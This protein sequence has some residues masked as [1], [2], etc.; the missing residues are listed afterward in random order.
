MHDWQLGLKDPYS[1]LLTSDFR[2][3]GIHEKY[4]NTWELQL[5]GSDRGGICLYSTLSLR[6][7]STRIFPIFHNGSHTA[8]RSSEFIHPPIIKKFLSNYVLIHYT[9]FEG[10]DIHTHI[11]LP[12]N[13]TVLSKTIL[14]NNA[15]LPFEGAINWV[16]TLTPLQ[17]GSA[18][19]LEE[20]DRDFYLT[21]QAQDAYAAF[22]LGNG[23]KAGATSYPSLF[24]PLQIAPGGQFAHQW[25]F[26]CNEDIDTL[27]A[28]SKPLLQADFEPLAARMDVLQ[29]RDEIDI[30]TTSS[31]W[32]AAFAFSQKNALQLILPDVEQDQPAT[33]LKSRN[34]EQQN[35][36]YLHDLPPIE[37]L[38]LL[39]IWYLSGVIPGAIST[40]MVLLD[41]Y[42]RHL[43]S[44]EEGLSFQPYPILAEMIWKI[45]E[46]TDNLTW[47]KL[48]YP[49]LIE[50]LKFWFTESQD[51]DQD[52][53][54]EWQ[55]ALQSQF[56][57]L[58]VHNYWHP[59]GA[60]T[61]TSWIESPFL[62]GLLY[63]ELNR[64][65][66]IAA[67]LEIT[68]EK[69]WLESK[70]KSLT[71]YINDSFHNR[72][73]IFKYR[74]SI[75]HASPNGYKIFETDQAG[76]YKINKNLR[77]LQRLNIKII[78]EKENTRKTRIFIKGK[79]NEGNTVEEISTR[80]FMGSDHLRAATSNQVY[81]KIISIEVENLT[82]GD[83]VIVSTAD[84]AVEDI[85]S[86]FPLWSNDILPQRVKHIKERWLIPEL[87]QPFGLPLVPV[88]KQPKKSD[89]FN[90][91]DLYLNRFILE[92]LIN[93]N[94]IKLASELYTNL[95]NAVIKNLKLFKR[96]YKT[97]DASDGY[98]SGDYNIVNGLLPVETFLKLIGI[99]FWS[100]SKIEFTHYN[101]FDEPIQVQNRA[102]TVVCGRDHFEIIFPGGDRFQIKGIL[103]QRFFLTIPTTNK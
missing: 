50:S 47:L 9:P 28:K 101:P 79:T 65:V 19:K 54:P 74:D 34:P 58:P 86:I 38:S 46:K 61:N 14:K 82:Q 3:R 25:V 77:G 44:S 35:M 5:E 18:A 69:A 27:Y 16:M 62:A 78:N 88:S 71:A 91:V 20:K 23:A 2:V 93:H 100:E 1:L 36:V 55:H 94:Q 32:D 92:G 63:H 40:V 10:L 56:E 102:T 87:M 57:Q 90:N 70:Q 85:T 59:A 89:L 81:T 64:T 49:V 30:Q 67:C 31:D 97:Y 103:P 26:T 84:Y 39:D 37:K 52:A 48:A 95:T 75:T 73:K 8:D 45:Y 33:I 17:A 72:K 13:Q 83:Q 68:N 4:D 76:L 22:L 15:A 24:L 11:W 21:G 42:L 53:I 7:L 29:Q 12:D 98:G 99:S 43:V 80:Q 6:T 66:Q 41:R 96:F 51:R 60:G